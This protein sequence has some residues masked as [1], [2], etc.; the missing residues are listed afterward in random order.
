MVRMADSAER[1]NTTVDG[2]VSIGALSIGA[3][4]IGVLGVGRMG[5]PIAARLVAAG[6]RVVVFDQ[7]NRRDAATA[8]G[9]GWASSAEHL[10][11][12]AEIFVTILPG[13]AELEATLAGDDG[14]VTTLRP[15]SLWLDLTS[16]APDLTATLA[17]AATERGIEV[18][19]APMGGGPADAAAGTLS[20]YVAGAAAAVLRALPVL[21]ALA[22]ADRIER[23]GIRPEDAQT[24]KLLANLLWFGQAVAATEALLLGTGLGVDIETLRRV[25]PRSAGASRFLDGHLDLLLAGDNAETF[26]LARVVEELDS[27]AALAISTGTPFE[28]SALVTRIHHEALERFGPVD[29]ELLAAR[30]IE[31]RAGRSLGGL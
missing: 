8:V 28:L 30:L 16:G 18:V 1:D 2:A 15:G 7:A 17:N 24:I 5:L 3:A 12:Q 22:A 19:A 25:L 10:A 13:R 26:G 29:G 23:V 20:L 14:L 11:S 21:G 27:V 31:Q 6:F 9:A 4:S